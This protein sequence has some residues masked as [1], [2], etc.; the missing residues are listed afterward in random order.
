L[1]LLLDAGILCP[2]LVTLTE[3]AGDCKRLKG[4]IRVFMPNTKRVFLFTGHGFWVR[5]GKAKVLVAIDELEKH[6]GDEWRMAITEMK[7]CTDE[8]GT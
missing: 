7:G 6:T 2:E 1:Q 4:D 5:A 8:S 3:V